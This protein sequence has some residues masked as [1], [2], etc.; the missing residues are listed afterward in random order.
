MEGEQAQQSAPTQQP[1][2][3]DQGLPKPQ[4]SSKTLTILL[5]TI[6]ILSLC[7]SGYLAYQNYLLRQ[8]I[9]IVDDGVDSEVTPEPNSVEVIPTS[10]PDPT[11][12]W[13][14]YEGNTYSFKYPTSWYAKEDN[15]EYFGDDFV[16]IE[17]PDKTIKI[18]VTP[19][20]IPYGFGGDAVSNFVNNPINVY[21]FG[22]THNVEEVIQ[23]ETNYFVDFDILHEGQE[24][25]V[26][27]GTGYPAA[28]DN[29]RSVDDYNRDKD[30]ILK[31]LS[32]FELTT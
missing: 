32:T 1:S 16:V 5:V 24:I 22:N 12:N 13:E 17:N 19:F 14:E 30:T 27:Y 21:M 15:N 9:S 3:D 29:N 11:S 18:Q 6:T 8:E 4:K 10:T 25:Y 26:I 2:P 31:I 20:Q 28:S 23:D 7:L